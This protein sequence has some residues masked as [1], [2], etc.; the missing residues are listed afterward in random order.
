MEEDLK[1]EVRR[2]ELAKSLLEQLDAFSL[3]ERYQLEMVYLGI[4]ELGLRGMGVMSVAELAIKLC[5]W[6]KKQNDK[7]RKEQDERE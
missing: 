2:S 5:V 3:P 7:R 6:H 4:T 1:D